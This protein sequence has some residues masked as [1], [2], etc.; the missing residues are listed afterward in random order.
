[1]SD[2]G[3]QSMVGK[4]KKALLMKPA[5]AFRSQE[6]VDLA[7]KEKN[8]IGRPDF[9]RAIQ[10][11]DVF[12]Q[13]LVDF[14]VELEFM[15]SESGLGMDAIYTRDPALVTDSGAIQGNMGNP[16]RLDEP[17]RL[18]GRMQDLGIPLKGQI[19]GDGRIEAGDL[20]WLDERTLAVGE[21]FRSNREGMRQLKDILEG[22]L[23][24]IIPVPLPYWNGPLDCLHLMSL[25]SPVDQDVYL[26]YSRLMAVPFRQTL[27]ERGI[28]LVEVPDEEYETLGCN[29]LALAPGICIMLAG[30]PLTR[31]RLEA[32]GI[33]VSVFEGQ[34]ICLKGLGGPTCLTQPLLRL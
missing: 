29:V 6:E 30:N 7:W 12:I 21:G 3:A 18:A 28:R 31:A 10:E 26:V 32:Q 8:W 16:N 14:G 2:F 24:T 11:Y 25:L 27:L 13:L 34:E 22:H 17:D 9:S 5:D 19:S 1:M 23:D 4:L 20:V 33:E 15:D